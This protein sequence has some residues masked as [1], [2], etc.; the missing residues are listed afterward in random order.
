MNGLTPPKIVDIRGGFIAC[1]LRDE[2]PEN[3][4]LS[5]KQTLNE[6]TNP[7][8]EEWFKAVDDILGQL[9][10]LYDALDGAKKDLGDSRRWEDSLSEYGLETK[11]SPEVSE[12]IETRSGFLENMRERIYA[13][14]EILAEDRYSWAETL[15]SARACKFLDTLDHEGAPWDGAVADRWYGAVS[16]RIRNLAADLVGPEYSDQPSIISLPKHWMVQIKA[17]IEVLKGA[18]LEDYIARVKFDSMDQEEESVWGDDPQEED[19]ANWE[20]PTPNRVLWR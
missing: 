18:S 7:F 4:A 5:L 19:V 13:T 15:G 3:C 1:L 10:E 14:A 8:S 16:E 6:K 11:L 2:V 12:W 20:G 9:K 17:E